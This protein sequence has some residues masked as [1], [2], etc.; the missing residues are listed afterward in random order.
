M[1]KYPRPRPDRFTEKLI[2]IR[3]SLGLS[4]DGML[5]RLGMGKNRARSS[6]SSYEC[7][8]SEPPLPV[9]LQYARLAGVCMDFIVDDELDLP[10]RLPSTPMHRGPKT[11]A[12]RQR[13]SKR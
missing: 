9:L 4:Q 2:Q 13:G 7:G 5:I 12:A 1:G 3:K 8:K 6:V 10:K 11:A